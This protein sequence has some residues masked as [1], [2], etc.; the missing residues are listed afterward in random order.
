MLAVGA[1]GQGGQADNLARAA[2]LD[3]GGEGESSEG[4]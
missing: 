1:Q 2:G 4:V 3:P